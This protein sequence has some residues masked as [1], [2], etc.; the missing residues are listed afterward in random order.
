MIES[1][2]DYRVASL[3]ST[4]KFSDVQVAEAVS[5]DPTALPTQTQVCNI[6][7]PLLQC[8]LTVP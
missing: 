3:Q 1:T 4:I 8:C 6:V 2:Q 7:S 5:T